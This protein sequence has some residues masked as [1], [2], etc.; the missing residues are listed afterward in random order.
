MGELPALAGYD[1]ARISLAQAMMVEFFSLIYI[2]TCPP[3]PWR[4]YMASRLLTHILTGSF[5][6][7]DIFSRHRYA[8]RREEA[9]AGLGK[10]FATRTL[11][12]SVD[13]SVLEKE[14]HKPIFSLPFLKLMLFLIEVL[15]L[16]SLIIMYHLNSGCP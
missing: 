9:V 1:E 12:G 10:S 14:A 6:Q 8:S 15:P 13:S 5:T 11:I 7:P 4:K 2:S 3:F 16:L